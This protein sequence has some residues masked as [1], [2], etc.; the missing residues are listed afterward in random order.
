MKILLATYPMAHQ[1]PGGG[2]IQIL[3]YKK[4]LSKL[5]HKVSYFNQWKDKINKFDLVHFFSCIG[6]SEHF[7]KYV[8]DIGLPL[9]ISPN[10]WINDKNKKN[11]NLNEIKNILSLSDKIIC[12][13][14]IESKSLIK[15]FNLNKNSFD[16]VYNG[17]D[18]IFFQ[19]INENIF[20]KKYKINYPFILNVANIE[21][22][23]N[24]LKLVEVCNK[25][26]K[27][28]I[29]IGHIRD[30]KY[31]ELINQTDEK[32]ILKIIPNINHNSIYLRSAYKACKYFVLPSTLETPGLSSLEAAAQGK[33]LLITEEG[34]CR[35]YYEKKV[36]YCNNSNLDKKLEELF[37]KPA[38][39][40]SV[41]NKVKK[42]EWSKSILRLDKVYK[43]LIK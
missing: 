24:Q 7:C 40:L 13:S 20:R 41:I 15:I 28:L 9:V 30:K 18:K 10:L 38:I 35:E 14:K 2:E 5:G 36:L 19:Q 6:G 12:N 33:N 8:K 11:Y 43:S 34:S 22:R 3:Y 21:K 25:L 32:K 17:V 4:Y 27:K 42:F 26:N 29:I 23:K 31:Y 37:K 39:S 16:Y 1:T